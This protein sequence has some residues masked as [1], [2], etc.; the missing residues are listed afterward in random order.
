MD[1]PGNLS[2]S[3]DNRINYKRLNK[4]TGIIKEVDWHIRKG[5]SQE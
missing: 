1:L 3:A 2:V 5:L 4:F